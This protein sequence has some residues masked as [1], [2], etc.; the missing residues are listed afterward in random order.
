M[1]IA[2]LIWEPFTVPG[3]GQ[4]VVPRLMKEWKQL[5]PTTW[6]F[7]IAD[8]A[9]FHDGSP[10]T[11]ADV[12]W[13]MQRLLKDPAQAFKLPV[14][15]EKIAADGDHAIRVVTQAP[16]SQLPMLA[17]LMTF[18][19]KKGS[20]PTKPI[21]SGPFKLESWSN[22][23]AR[24]TRFD[25]YHGGK[26]G[27]EHIE[28]TPFE[29]TTS[30]T[31]A[32]FGGQVDL[33]QAV[34]PVAAKSAKGRDG[35]QIVRRTGDSVIPIIM[36]TSSGPFADKRVREAVRLG[37]DRKALVDQALAGYGSVA[38]DVLGTADPAL[39]KSLTRTRDVSRAKQLLSQAKFDTS[40]TYQLF[41]T[42]EAP[43]Q[44]EAMKLAAKQLADIG[45][46][47]T[48]VEQDSTTFYDK[49][50]CKADLYCGYWGT[51]DSIAFFGGKTLTSS[52]T[53]NETDWHDKEFDAAY[54][55]LLASTDAAGQKAGLQQMQRIEHERSGYVVW[56]TS[57]GVDLAAKGVK[58]LPTAPGYGRVLLEK[59]TKS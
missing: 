4:T 26:S 44:V 46:K 29:D 24:L 34:G 43:G 15:P 14:I 33:A 36:K 35:I 23:R 22:G 7:T 47:V 59:V 52:A 18:V 41:V 20:S 10:V 45:L 28:V 17:R 11:P 8:G 16:N 39:D 6:R 9:R 38:G 51:N 48:V 27:V 3:N 58:G 37:V 13:S 12:V 31:N 49:T 55:K 57:D 32:M 25:G 42:S 21:G 30:L 54:S 5:T 1:L 40:R 50:W 56:G 19:M 2:S 53:A